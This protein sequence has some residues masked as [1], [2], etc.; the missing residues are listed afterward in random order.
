M[1]LLTAFAIIISCGLAVV[2]GWSIVNFSEER[3]L[4]ASSG[5]GTT[6]IERWIGVPGLTGTALDASLAQI[7]DTSD[8]DGARKREESLATLLSVRPLSSESW[9]S[10]AEMRLVT[11]Q[12]FNQVL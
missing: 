8:P 10:F 7:S 5:G 12:P 6:D 4:L 11:S 9:L 3:A 1:R 2:R